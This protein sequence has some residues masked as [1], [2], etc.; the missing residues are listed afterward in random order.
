MT[1]VL[2]CP[3]CNSKN[4]RS[5]LDVKS[6]S[7][8][9]GCVTEA[10][11]KKI[12]EV[13]L[14]VSLCLNCGLGFNSN[15]P[16]AED[17]LFLYET[18][19][20]VIAQQANYVR[21]PLYDGIFSLL[22]RYLNKEDKIVEIGCSDGYLLQL[23]RDAGYRNCIGIE[24]GPHCKEAISKGLNVINSYFEADTFIGRD[25]DAFYL[26]HVFEHFPDP[27]SI[28]KSMKMQ[29]MPTGKIIIEVPYFCHF[30]PQHLY[31]YNV[32]FFTNLTTNLNLKIVELQIAESK[33]LIGSVLRIVL[34]H[35]TEKNIEYPFSESP[36]VLASFAL[37][38]GKMYSMRYQD[39]RDF[40]THAGNN[41]LYWWG[42][43][44]V[45]APALYAVSHELFNCNSVNVIDSS[46]MKWGLWMPGTVFQVQ[47][48]TSI[49]GKK[50]KHLVIASDYY[51]EILETIKSADIEAENIFVVT[52]SDEFA[53]TQDR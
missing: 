6:L 30:I 50:I 43:G 23:L 9:C 49:A 31:Y 15:P 18:F 44:G 16:S 14:I 5:F 4:I 2:H 8:D 42:A 53:I 7:Y 21:K 34:T 1:N 52:I 13:D 27:F 33:F 19:S 47:P 38:Q 46:P 40:I 22:T 10:E 45:S 32:L 48:I 29:L 20:P 37:K 24:P 51:L 12:R 41:D 35:A 11:L 28:L 26:L 17:R 36:E 3:Y 25:V 39:L